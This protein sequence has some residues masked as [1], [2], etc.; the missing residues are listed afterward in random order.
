MKKAVIALSPQ[1]DLDE[2]LDYFYDTLKLFQGH[3][4]FSEISIVSVIHP[5]LY[6]MPTQWYKDSRHRLVKEAHQSLEKRVGQRLHFKS[7]K[8]L[9][10]S[11]DSLE[12]LSSMVSRHA[13]HCGSDVLVVASND[14]TGL[15]YWILGSFSETTA[16]TAR[17]PTLIIKP[18]VSPDQFAPTAHLLVCIDVK[19]PPSSKDL[20]WISHTAKANG[21]ALELLYVKPKTRIFLDVTQPEKTLKEPQKVLDAIQEKLQ[22]MGLR[23]NSSILEEG[24]S[25]AQTVVDFAEQKQTWA[26]I[27]VAAS[28]SRLRKLLLGSQARRILALTQRPF[29]SLRLE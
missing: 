27:T 5:F 20:R 8:V 7:I 26:I 10:S 21:A 4:F 24:S 14:R 11:S 12:H 28:R 3:G 29:L 9:A 13:R 22:K 17:H 18:H 23:V 16:L 1:Q 25:L 6:L 2:N 15:P 19:A